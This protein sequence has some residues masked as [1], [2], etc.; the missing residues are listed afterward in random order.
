LNRHREPRRGVAIQRHRLLDRHVPRLKAGVLA[1]TE[2]S[3]SGIYQPAVALL[4]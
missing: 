1:M 4:R 2:T 3:M